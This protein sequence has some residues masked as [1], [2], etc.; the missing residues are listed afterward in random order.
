MVLSSDR[1]QWTVQLPRFCLAAHAKEETPQT[2]QHAVF[3]GNPIMNV[4][5]LGKE[6]S[7]FHTHPQ[8][9][10]GKQYP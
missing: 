4:V 6:G 9:W 3:P 5:D 1:Q 10:S 7:A 8:K 2:A